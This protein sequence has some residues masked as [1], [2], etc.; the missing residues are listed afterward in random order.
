MGYLALL[1]CAPRASRKYTTNE[2]YLINLYIPNI[3][4]EKPS[5][6]YLRRE[7]YIIN[8]LKAK[9]LIKVNILGSEYILINIGEKKLLIRSCDNLIAKIKIKAKDNMKVY[10]YIRNQKKVVLL[11]NT[12]TRLSVELRTFT[13]LPDRD[14]L[15][16]LSYLEAYAYIVDANIPFIYVKNNTDS[17]IIISRYIDLETL[18]EYNVEYYYIV[19]SD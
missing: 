18:V 13:P 3:I 2:Y 19:Y 5:L 17:A 7:V 12:V 9:I 4:K 6:V 11:L 1:S 8:D 16:K 15:F 14:Y 10:Y